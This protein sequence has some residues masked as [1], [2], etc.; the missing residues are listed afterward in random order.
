MSTDTM[1]LSMKFGTDAGK[2][3]VINIQPCKPGLTASDVSDAMD[4]M[5]S[6]EVFTL[7]LSGKLGASIVERSVTDLF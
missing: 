4:L 1:T 3:A 7:G 5:I 6:S 2:S